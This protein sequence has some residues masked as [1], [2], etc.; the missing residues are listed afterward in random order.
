MKNLVALAVITALGVAG[1]TLGEDQYWGDPEVGQAYGAAIGIVFGM[2]IFFA[3][4]A[5][6]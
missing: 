2:L 6:E 5:R 1:W 4:R 3:I